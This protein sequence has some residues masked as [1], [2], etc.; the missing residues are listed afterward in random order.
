MRQPGLA[1]DWSLVSVNN[2]A[3]SLGL[4]HYSLDLLMPDNLQ[5]FK[6]VHLKKCYIYCEC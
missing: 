4:W 2:A 3:G 6:H 1:T 5:M